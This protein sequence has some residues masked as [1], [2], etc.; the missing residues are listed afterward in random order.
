MLIGSNASNAMPSFAD[1]VRARKAH[2]RQQ[3]ARREAESA[4]AAGQE[5]VARQA[6]ARAAAER[7]AWESAHPVRATA[8][9]MKRAAMWMIKLPIAGLALWVA[10][11]ASQY[12]QMV[13]G[14][15]LFIVVAAIVVGGPLTAAFS[16]GIGAGL[17]A[18]L[19]TP[20]GP[21]LGAMLV[22]AVL[23]FA[24]QA[25]GFVVTNVNPLMFMGVGLAVG[26][27]I[28][29]FR[30]LALIARRAEMGNQVGR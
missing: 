10:I 4:Q 13:V 30:P 29:V 18:V 16:G 3:A 8:A 20:L 1:E 23:G 9:D 25:A 24:F 28:A 26:V 27:L 6:A 19:T 17:A 2:N 11:W 12:L 14:V 21:I 7:R 15:I 22:G 5:R